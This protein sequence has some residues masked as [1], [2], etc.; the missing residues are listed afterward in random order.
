MR[1]IEFENKTRAKKVEL[2]K[3][4]ELLKFR[5]MLI[6]LA[7][8]VMLPIGSVCLPKISDRDKALVLSVSQK[9]FIV[10]P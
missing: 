10:E 9:Y 6:D 1:V 2:V 7:S 3:T 8:D 5:G 4:I